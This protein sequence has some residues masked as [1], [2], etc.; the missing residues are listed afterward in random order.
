MLKSNIEVL[1]S[2]TVSCPINT[3]SSPS[4]FNPPL[5]SSIHPFSRNRLIP[6]AVVLGPIGKEVVHDNADDRQDEDEDTPQDLVERWAVRFEDFHYTTTSVLVRVTR[7]V[8]SLTPSKDV[9]HEHD[10]SQDAA[11]GAVLPC[12]GLGGEGG[13]GVDGGG[14]REGREA[15]LEEEAEHCCLI[16]VV[17]VFDGYFGG[18]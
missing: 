15:E 18:Q 10:E 11:S 12:V 2:E 4:S 9:N 14:E 17:V 8:W 7:D 1:L 13:V 5:P 3:F 16:A 6:T